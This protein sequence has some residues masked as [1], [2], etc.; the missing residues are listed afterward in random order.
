MLEKTPSTPLD[1]WMA[2]WL[3]HQRSLG[4]RYDGAEW[5][6]KHLRGFPSSQRRTTPT[7]IQPALIDG[8]IPFAT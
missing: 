3:K 7:S 5:I 2:A 8:A 6:L 4:R 1:R